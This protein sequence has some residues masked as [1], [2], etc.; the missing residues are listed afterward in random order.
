[1]DFN[2]GITAIVGPNGSGKSNVA[3]AIRWVL[4]EQSPKALRGGKMLD[5]I[6]SGTQLRKALGLAEVVLSIDNSNGALPID[7]PEVIITRRVLRS[8]E[9]EYFINKAQ[10]RLKDVTDLFLD[11]GLGKEGYSIIGQGRIDEILSIHPGERRQ[12]FEQAAGIGKYKMRKEEAEIKLQKTRDN[13]TRIEDIIYEIEQQLSQL[14]LQSD[15]AHEYNRVKQDLKVAE[16]NK[17]IRLYKRCVEKHEQTTT[18]LKSQAEDLD[19]R[20][21]RLSIDE[22]TLK[23][24]KQRLNVILKEIEALKDDRHEKVTIQARLKGEYD[25]ILEKTN[26]LIEENDLLDQ[27][28]SA[29]EKILTEK[30]ANI[31]KTNETLLSQ[32]SII[33]EKKVILAEIEQ[34]LYR[35]ANQ[36]MIDFKSVERNKQSISGLS[37]EIADLKTSLA[38]HEVMRDRITNEINEMNERMLAGIESQKKLSENI[39]ALTREFDEKTKA[40]LVLKDERHADESAINAQNKAIREC[41]HTINNIKQKIESSKS[42]LDILESMHINLEGFNLGVKNILRAKSQGK[43]RDLKVCGVVAELMEVDKEYRSAIEA[44]LGSSLQHV[45]TENE[46]DAKGIIEFLRSNEYGR[47]TFLPITSVKSKVLSKAESEA[48]LLDGSLGVASRIVRFEEKYRGIFENLLGRTVITETIEQA[49]YMAKK[50][51]YSFRI[52][53]IKADVVNPGGSITGGESI[54]KSNTIIGRKQEIA[55]LRAELSVF[56]EALNQKKHILEDLNKG[57]N[58]KKAEFKSITDNIREGEINLVIV[59]QRLESML[60]ENAKLKFETET[61]CNRKSKLDSDIEETLSKLQQL[62]DRLGILEKTK[63]N[64]QSEAQKSEAEIENVSVQKDELEKQTTEI[65]NYISFYE[66]EVSALNERVSFLTADI[67]RYTEINEKRKQKKH[68]NM[69]ARADLEAQASLKKHETEA[70]EGS[71]ELLDDDICRKDG[72]KQDLA[73]SLAIL[74]SSIE[75]SRRFISQ[76]KDSQYKIELKIS[77][78]ETEMEHLDK[79]IWEEY[80]ISYGNALEYLDKTLDLNLIEDQIYSLKKHKDDLGEVNLNSIEDYIKL[81]IRYDTLCAQKHDLL[82]AKRNLDKVIEEMTTSMK[83]EFCSEFEIINGYFSTVFSQLFGGGKAQLILEDES[84]PLDCGIEIAAQPPGKKLQSISLLSGGEKALTASAILFAI[85]KRKPALFCVLDEIDAVLDESNLYNLGDFL[86]EFSSSTQFIIITH[87]KVTMEMCD[88]LYGV[89]M[90]EKGISK[91]VSVKLEG[92][93][94]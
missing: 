25:V 58:A 85:L 7:K 69:I 46:E 60:S 72:D 54:R 64:F 14:K 56:Q 87:R 68:E 9:N 31:R 11:T 32:K 84:R 6:F 8:G 79:N 1:M 37:E 86:R 49:I 24:E 5:V 59:K 71:V 78:L 51:G 45:I 70:L 89:V 43:L 44:C 50:F 61:L 18:Q 13:I 53:T 76:I 3:D 92:I 29:D 2:P 22:Y 81:K 52:V 48:L 47:A 30:Q 15:L 35:L 4:G 20:Y 62:A 42:R 34:K 67:G 74:E 41:E 39:N 12:V 83:K 16:I 63:S 65:K 94:V 73:E 80:K 28:I 88:A 82:E 23:E 17:F 19:S 93:A 57:L 66:R 36:T 38:K 77:K 90:E 55:E 33:N 75:E 10:S 91:L 27:E 40:L 26:R 21:S